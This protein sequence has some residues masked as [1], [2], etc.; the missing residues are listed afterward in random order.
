[1]IKHHYELNTCRAIVVIIVAIIVLAV[2]VCSSWGRIALP[3]WR[4][5]LA[6]SYLEEVHTEIKCVSVKI[7]K[8][9]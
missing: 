9:K 6:K 2:V 7:A 1:M 3:L 8:Y 5:A 4:W